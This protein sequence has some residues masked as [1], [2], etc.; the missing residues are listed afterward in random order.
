[1]LG[2]NGKLVEL[3]KKGFALIVTD[4]HGNLEDFNKFMGIWE[5]FDD[6]DNHFILAGD[7]I[8]SMDGK[9]GSIE[10]LES[11][12]S[13]WE[14]SQNFHLL[15]GNH[16]WATLAGVSVYKGGFNQTISFESLLREKFRMDG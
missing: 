6:K 16:E 2:Y 13:R 14:N 3:P 7:F 5:K 11:L 1:M 10:I 12:K 15:L 8:H 4:I 9:D